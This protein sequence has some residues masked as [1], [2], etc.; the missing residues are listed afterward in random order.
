M[1]H[2]FYNPFSI[3]EKSMKKFALLFVF[4][5]FCVSAFA[6]HYS[7]E[8][9]L[10]IR[11]AGS[12]TFSPDAKRIA[13]LTNITGTNQ[14]WFMDAN[15]GYPEQITAF[16]DNISFV[17]W[18][19]D[20]KGSIFGKAVGGNE[21]T[22]FF[23]LSNDGANIKQ[24][25]ND[26]KT[27]YNFGAI[28][29]DGSAIFYTSNKRDKNWFDVYRMEIASGKEEMLLQNDS[30]NSVAA[31]SDDGTRIVVSRSSVRFSLDNDLYLI[32]TKT[33]Q[34]RHLT[35]HDEA[36]Q[37]GDVHFLPDNKTLV[38]GT[39]EKR[40]FYNLAEMSLKGSTYPTIP[41]IADKV[42]VIDKTD[43]DLDASTV[44]PH[45]DFFAYTTNREGFSELFL[46]QIETDGKPLISTV[47]TKTEQITLPAKGIASGLEFSD[48]GTKLAFTFSGAK[49]NTDIWVY[50][51]Q[52]K[53][54]NQVTKSSR[55]GIPQDSFVEPELIKYKSF[56]GKEITAW[57]YKPINKH[58]F[59]ITGGGTKFLQEQLTKAT[60]LPVIVSVHGGPEGQERPGFNPLYQYYLSRGYA[61]LATNVRG[62]TGY[63]KTFA[64]LDDVEKREDSVKDLA[65]SVEW[66]KTSGGADAKRIAVMGG[67]YGGYMTMAAIT[68]YPE[69]FAAAVNTVGIVNWE[70]FLKN[71]SGYRRRQREVEYG[72][73]DKDIEFLRGISPIAKV[74][75]IKTPLFVIHGKN[76]PRV[77]YTEAEQLV[78]AL[79]KRNV[80]VE[81]KLYDDE[82]HGISK[83]KN[84]LDLYP[85]VADF[86]DK[87]MK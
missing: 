9:Y 36:T 17:E 11:S 54:L 79:R 32:D 80:S 18:L 78:E 19:P 75:K 62:S 45:N 1:K 71:T 16:Q 47:E 87:Y 49:Y 28:S 23:H 81:Y 56:D 10:N 68:L 46:R 50:D 83:L 24:L 6:Q 85:R 73:L 61:I 60:T 39:N 20:N 43:W 34:V 84:R 4:A 30:S 31:V 82:G 63:G 21:N 52:T 51:L 40:E 2:K 33:K 35:P 22:Q 5:V 3:L 76:D 65:A 37:Y 74:D 41:E 59:M 25:T 67:S 55:S 70:T 72:M 57:Y 26:E 42:R 29:K 86:L 53:K 12:P 77:P 13:F 58:G 14:I 15:G 69:L 7:I 64:H 27:R 44:S 66:L 38:F 8:R 48:D